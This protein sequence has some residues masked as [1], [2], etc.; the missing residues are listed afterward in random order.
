MSEKKPIFD[1][2]GSFD[3]GMN[4][5]IDPL[6]LKPSQM[7]YAFNLTNR[8]DFVKTR[9][10]MRAINLTFA[11]S[12]V[13]PTFLTAAVAQSNFQTG[14][15]QGACYYT[16]DNGVGSIVVAIGGNLFQIV[17]DAFGNAV[18]TQV[19]GLASD[20][21]LPGTPQNVVATA[22]NGQVQ[23]IW[24]AAAN[25]TSYN[26]S[27]G[28]ASGGPYGTDFASGTN[29]FLDTTAI[30][31]TAYYYVVSANSASGTGSNSTQVSATPTLSVPNAP[32][33]VSALA[34]NTTITISWNQV[35]GLTYYVYRGTT[36]GGESGTPIASALSAGSYQ[37]TGLSNGTK[38][39]YVVKAHNS[40]GYSAFSSE[41]S[42][43]P[44]SVPPAA[45]VQSS[46][47]FT[48]GYVS[49]NWAGSSGATSYN[50]YRGTSS[51]GES[52]TPI[53][54]GI[55]GSS[56][57][58]A[59]AAAG[60]T[61]YYTVKAVG[62]LGTSVAS[63]EYGVTLGANLVTVSN[64]SGFYINLSISSGKIY[65]VNT[66]NTGYDP[67][68]Y[69]GG[70]VTEYYLPGYIPATNTYTSMYLETSTSNG[71]TAATV[72]SVTVINS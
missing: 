50:V 63:N 34:G 13:C 60:N 70:Q 38:Y 37:D 45:P 11:A 52:G 12:P 20:A 10:A 29:S 68:F 27:R 55:T 6:K 30:N 59:T 21:G 14:L 31:G 47:S 71:P 39:F 65:L 9:P 66:T 44:S 16:P 67:T 28:T 35:A 58:D 1:T 33:G 62:P 56:Y 46:P 22:G 43:T 8:G 48:T 18:V 36:S 26:I 40:V 5:G 15:F 23:L 24:T 32:T 61:Y 42:A 2:L 4:S 41:V 51:G 17:P 7:G 19:N 49:V 57:Q 3:L 72:C 69:V 25:A 53:A 64:Y 54:T